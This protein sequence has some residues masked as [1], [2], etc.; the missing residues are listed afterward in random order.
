[1][2]YISI[3]LHLSSLFKMTYLKSTC[4]G[5]LSFNRYTVKWNLFDDV[6]IN[7]FFKKR[8]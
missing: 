8:S 5:A 7:R 2:Y 1:M 3:R 6:I 4:Y